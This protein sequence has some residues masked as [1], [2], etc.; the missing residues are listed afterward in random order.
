MPCGGCISE[1]AQPCGGSMCVHA[2]LPAHLYFLL[3]LGQQPR[4][5]MDAGKGGME[6]GAV[7]VCARIRPRACVVVPGGGGGGVAMVCR[8]KHADWPAVAACSGPGADPRS[9]QAVTG[10]SP[11]RGSAHPGCGS[12]RRPTSR[13]AIGRTPRQAIP[14]GPELGLGPEIY[15]STP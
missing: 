9:L 7:T 15:P 2:L 1:P 6:S 8:E 13:A 12:L 3:H 10:L 4:T 14:G 11:G 5:F